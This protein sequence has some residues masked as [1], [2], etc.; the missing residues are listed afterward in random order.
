MSHPAQDL[1]G[2]ATPKPKGQT[3]SGST[4]ASEDHP[5][6]SEETKQK[7]EFDEPVFHGAADLACSI[8]EAEKLSA[9]SH[10]AM[11]RIV[12]RLPIRNAAR[13]L[14]LTSTVANDGGE[15]AGG[16]RHHEQAE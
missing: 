15:Q 9:Q 3:G 4:S 13:L 10:A 1:I 7:Y 14:L 16:N 11:K 12:V 6:D 8:R 5:E 2:N